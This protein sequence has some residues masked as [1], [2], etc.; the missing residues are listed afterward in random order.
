MGSLRVTVCSGVLVAAAGAA[1]AGAATPGAATALAPA[2]HAGEDGRVWVFPAAPAPGSDVTLR[3]TGC[4]ERT[5]VAAST[6]FVADARL[7]VTDAGLTGES[8]VRSTLEPGTYTVRVTCGAAERTGTFTVRAGDGQPPAP[9]ASS[10]A[11]GQPA[12]P[13]TAGQ[14][15]VPGAVGQPPAPGTGGRPPVPEGGGRSPLPQ[16]DG[17]RSAPEDDQQSSPEDDQPSTRDEHG[18]P[19]SP[20]EDEQSSATRWPSAHASPVA[21]VEAGGGGAADLVTAADRGTDP[22]AAQGLTGLMIAAVG[23]VAVTLGRVRRS[24]GAR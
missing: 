12:S 17:Q 1:A 8:R 4:A 20:G 22:A 10:E 21:P 23:A 7:T 14:S 13:G 16:D 15:P 19:P 5:A 18:Q 3:V 2:A 11:A 6:A 24:R 9:G